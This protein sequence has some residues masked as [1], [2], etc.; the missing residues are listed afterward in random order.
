MYFFS[1]F[2]VTV[3]R[4]TTIAH[5]TPHFQTGFPEDRVKVR[6]RASQIQPITINASVKLVRVQKKLPGVAEF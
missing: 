6:M 4:G 1:F 3:E 5:A 2:L